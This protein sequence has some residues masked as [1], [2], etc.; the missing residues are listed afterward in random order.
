MN[1]EGFHGFGYGTVLGKMNLVG[2]YNG[3][4]MSQ[5]EYRSRDEKHTCA[6]VLL[7]QDVGT[8]SSTSAS[9]IIVKSGLELW[10]RA[11]ALL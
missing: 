2:I 10:G 5:S 7:L 4:S 11:S 9:V 3:L 8:Q 1:G 6:A